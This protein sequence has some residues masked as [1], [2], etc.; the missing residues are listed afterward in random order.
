PWGWHNLNE[1][2]LS[3]DPGINSA[4]RAPG[5]ARAPR[6]RLWSEHLGVPAADLEGDPTAVVDER[7]RPLADEQLARL[8]RGE[9]LTH[10][11]VGLPGVSRRSARLL[12]PLEGLMVDG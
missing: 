6:P 11:V 1:P 10:R 12:G 9:P 4:C 3:N 5:L 8:R 2:P 7:W